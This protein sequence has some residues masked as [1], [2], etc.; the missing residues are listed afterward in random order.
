MIFL[1][2]KFCPHCGG[3]VARVE[4]AAAEAKKPCPRCQETLQTVTLGSVKASECPKCEGLWVDVE[5]FNAICA[6]REQQA[7]VLG[8]ASPLPQPAHPELTLDE[9][10]YLHC[11]TCRTLMNRVNFAGRS[12]VVVDVCRGHGT[13]FDRDELQHIVE[14]IR[15][16]GLENARAREREQLEQARH[17]QPA[18]GASIEPVSDGGGAST[19]WREGWDLVDTLMFVGGA[20][21][22]LFFK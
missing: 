3:R 18:A 1:G 7:A 22:R 15:A 19:N 6:D 13:W 2:S 21:S 9:V 20:I 16:G 12:G 14:F 5:T 10:R 4:A 11:P 8:G 17:H